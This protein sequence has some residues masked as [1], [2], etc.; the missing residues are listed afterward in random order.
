MREMRGSSPL[1]RGK[2][3]CG[4]LV[5]DLR[6]L[7]PAHAGKTRRRTRT[8]ARCGAHPRS[9][10]ENLKQVA[11]DVNK[12]GSSPLTRGKHRVVRY[13]SVIP[14]LI[15]AHAGKTACL[16]IDGVVV[17]AHPRSRGENLP[18]QVSRSST[19]GSSP[20][21]RGKL[22]QRDLVDPEAGLIPAHAGKTGRLGQTHPLGGAHPR[23]RGENRDGAGLLCD[24]W[25]SS[26]LTRGK[27]DREIEQQRQPGL[28]PAHAGK[29]RGR[30]RSRGRPAA[31]PRSRGENGQGHHERPPFGGSSPLTRG[32]LDFGHT[33]HGM[34]RLIPAHA[35]K[36]GLRNSPRGG[37]RAHPRSR[38]ENEYVTWLRAAQAGSSPLTRGK[39]DVG[40]VRASRRGLIPAH[41]GKTRRYGCHRRSGGGSSPLTRGKPI[42]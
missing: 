19:R 15:P 37:Y 36:T 38:G 42:H 9:R 5:D 29:T 33:V 35:G 21:T 17:R 34:V 12:A 1:T 11:R 30:S 10:G 27:H 16:T 20:L 40:G 3:G 6:W 18:P 8:L 2:R 7:I 4:G 13:D 41:A 31:H 14:R 22:G 32:K 39:R 25:G 23:S 26:P 28:I 24:L